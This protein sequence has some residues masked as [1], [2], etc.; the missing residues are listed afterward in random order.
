MDLL[1]KEAKSVVL[2]VFLHQKP[3]RVKIFGLFFRQNRHLAKKNRRKKV[4]YRIFLAR[5]LLPT[6][7]EQDWT[8]Q[9]EPILEDWSV[10]GPI[11]FRRRLDLLIDD[12]RP[13]FFRNKNRFGHAKFLKSFGSTWENIWG[14]IR[15]MERSTCGLYHKQAAP[16]NLFLQ[17]LCQLCPRRTLILGRAG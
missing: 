1:H 10:S 17:L 5:N 3:R 9:S 4:R 14:E 16:N 12:Q 6:R 8:N 11:Y 13:I 2:D 7:P 15:G